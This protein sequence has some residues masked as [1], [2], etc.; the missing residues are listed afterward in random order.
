MW[1]LV[2]SCVALADE[3][4]AI[5]LPTGQLQTVGTYPLGRHGHSVTAVGQGRYFLHGAHIYGNLTSGDP[6]DNELLMRRRHAP[7]AQADR[8]AVLT[9]EPWMWL[10]D[11]RGWKRL[12]ELPECRGDPY[13]Q[14]ATP[15]SDGG[16]LLTGG[17]CDAPKMIDD[18]SGHPEYR[19]TSR[20]NGRSLTWEASPELLQGRIYHTASRLSDDSVLVVGGQRDPG[21]GGDVFPVLSSVE[22]LRDGTFEA[23]ADLQQARA[24]HTATVLDDDAIIV[25]GGFDAAGRALASVERWDRAGQSWQSLPPLREARHGHRATLLAD[26]RLLVT[27]GFGIDGKALSTAELWDPTGATW[28]EAAATPMP[29]GFH[30]ASTLADGDVLLV[31][32]ITKM[33]HRA[34]PMAYRWR[35]AS[36]RWE[37]A[38]TIRATDWQY[39]GF[40]PSVESQPDGSARIFGA[41]FIWRW[42]PEDADGQD[43]PRDWQ[44]VPALARLDDHSVMVVALGYPGGTAQRRAHRWDARSGAWTAAGT[45]QQTRSGHAQA[46]RLPSG[47]VLH[48]VEDAGNALH[49]E[50]SPVDLADS[51]W[52]FCGR[53][54][55][56]VLNDSPFELGLLPDG[57]AVVITN[58]EEAF[59]FDESRRQWQVARLEWRTSELAFGTPVRP[60]APLAQLLETS[61]SGAGT[62]L[63]VSA[64]AARF[65]GH[66]RPRRNYN[67]VSNGVVLRRVE[68]RGT[69]PAMLWN[70]GKGYWDYVFPNHQ[71][72]GRGAV[73]L[74]DGC[75]L[76]LSPP[77]I[78]D[79]KSGTARR[80]DAFPGGL[81]TGHN[82]IVVLTGGTVVA[83]SALVGASGSG[84]FSGEASCA[85]LAA[86]PEM[87]VAMPPVYARDPLPTPAVTSAAPT[88]SEQIGWRER[89]SERIE[90]LPNLSWLAMG[91]VVILGLVRWWIGCRTAARDSPGSGRLDQP[92]TGRTRH[93]LRIA[94]W[95]IVLAVLGPAV[96]NYWRFQKAVE[97]EECFAD[98]RAC[99]DHGSGLIQ[100]VPSLDDGTAGTR[101]RPHIPCRFVGQ[102]SAIHGK[103]IRRITLADDGTYRMASLVQGG[104]R[105]TEFR[106]N[107][108]VQSGHFVWRDGRGAAELDIN[109]IDSEDDGQFVLIEANGS[110]SRFERIEALA[111]SRCLPD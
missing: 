35:A 95:V 36:D 56:E 48:L 79:P 102:W 53:P 50:I 87:D 62:R 92:V 108:M 21:L 60:A 83:V 52:E 86:G 9:R 98:A 30:D 1:L 11:R 78:F 18:P 61:G 99:L 57:R 39:P 32:M 73:H 13:L 101:S 82:Q 45:L 44:G 40:I 93:L 111:S 66:V 76:S 43:R 14:A 29:V 105:A 58:F 72:I 106:G 47:R 10:P 65:W 16:I 81:N 41:A 100:S 17:L 68:G 20:L 37:L 84:W 2:L 33:D 26:G 15:L 3:P 80:L 97:G 6:K 91:V 67:I 23:G 49:C 70:P 103:Q 109:R 55:G 46:L 94:V 77:S 8:A 5:A 107:W 28:I 24:G 38:A 51:P 25:T 22:W 64:Q 4:G 19:G 88:K 7:P 63:D 59:I 69:P 85:G 71:N 31:P 75:A 110:R 12:G 74:P 34:Q 90:A 27:G 54:S 42:T 104:D 96:M 89:L